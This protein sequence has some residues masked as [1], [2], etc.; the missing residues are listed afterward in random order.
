MDLQ[1]LMSFRSHFRWI[2]HILLR[3]YLLICISLKRILKVT[4]FWKII[5]FRLRC[6]EKR[7]SF[8]IKLILALRGRILSLFWLMIFHI[9]TK[10]S[11]ILKFTWSKTKISLWRVFVP[12]QMFRWSFALIRH[13]TLIF[14]ILFLFLANIWRLTISLLF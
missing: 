13:K 9:L 10:I 7:L 12:I 2:H 5:C 3:V 6:S 4:F 11:L 8:Y 14:L 1:L